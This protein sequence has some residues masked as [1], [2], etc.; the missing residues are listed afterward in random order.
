MKKLKDIEYVGWGF[1]SV[2]TV[3]MI[4]L[5]L[6][7]SLQITHSELINPLIRVAIGIFAGLVFAA[8]IAASVNEVLHRRTKKKYLA[9]RKA[10]RKSKKKKKKKKK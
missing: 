5:G 10:A 2:V 7:F 8:I 6:L 4:P 1:F 9:E 3:F